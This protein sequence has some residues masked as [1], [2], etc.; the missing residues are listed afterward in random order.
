MKGIIEPALKRTVE[1]DLGM[2]VSAESAFLTGEACLQEL[3]A[4]Q[5]EKILELKSYVDQLVLEPGRL[6]RTD[7]EKDYDRLLASVCIYHSLMRHAGTI[8]E[9]FTTKGRVWAQIGKDLR[10]VTR[11][12]GT[13]GY[14][15]ACARDG[16]SILIPTQPRAAAEKVPLLP[17][18][19]TYYADSQY[20]LPLLG[21]LAADYPQLSA[22][23][24]ISYLTEMQQ[25]PEVKE[26]FHCEFTQA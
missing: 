9:V 17:E 16:D 22:A 4:K 8:E 25:N 19:F 14:L 12:I 21:S 23:T 2:R 15:A 10:R 1:G 20:L 11:I 5:P 3:L 24:A 26:S 13:G 18:N 6:P 7:E